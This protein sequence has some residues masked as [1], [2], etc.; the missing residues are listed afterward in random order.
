MPT[1]TKSKN[2]TAAKKTA[3]KKTATKKTATKQAATKKSVSRSRTS[4]T[5]AAIPGATPDAYIAAL[6]EPRRSEVRALHELIR[7]TLPDLPT[8]VASAMIGYGPFHYRSRSGC[9]GDAFLVGLSSRKAGI[10]IYVCAAD[11][12]GYLPELAAPELGKVDVGKG[13]IRIKKAADLD[14]AAFVRL[15]RRAREVGGMSAQG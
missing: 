12:K 10:S 2:R 14:Q 15:L 3:V 1:T 5:M 6:E 11:E 4:S 9:E 7:R 8:G 13:C